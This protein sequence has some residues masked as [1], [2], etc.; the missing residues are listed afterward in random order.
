MNKILQAESIE[1]NNCFHLGIY[2]SCK[3]PGYRILIK[4]DRI[5]VVDDD[6]ESRYIL[7]RLLSQSDYEVE[8]A[9]NGKEAVE[10]LKRAKFNLVLTDWVMP[11]MDGLELLGYVKS[12]YPDI[13]VIMVTLKAS[14]ESKTEVLELGAEG[15]LSK[16]YTKDQLLTIVSESLKKKK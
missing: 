13:S 6:P 2:I 4:K 3:C 12:Q 11:E 15:L 8:T 7:M 1:K 16:P 5:L 10:Q 14:S 9:K